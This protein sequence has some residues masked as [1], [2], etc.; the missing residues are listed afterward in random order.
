MLGRAAAL[1]G[2]ALTGLLV[3]CLT[4]ML[5]LVAAQIL[6][7]NALRASIPHTE[8]LLEWLVLWTAMLGAVAASLRSRH[9]TIDALSHLLGDAARRWAAVAAQSFAMAVCAALWLITG[10]FWLESMDY[11]ETTLGFAPRWIFES[12]VPAAFA[13][14]AAAHGWHAISLI[15]HG[16][17]VAGAQSATG[18]QLSE[19]SGLPTRDH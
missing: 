5:L 10:A 11:G 4:S 2:R 19:H 1:A 8:E 18:A 9:I 12:I 16:Q 6:S 13:V 17:L 14:M 15:R 7:R 3:F